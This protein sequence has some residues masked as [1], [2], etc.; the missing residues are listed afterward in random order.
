MCALGAGIVD[1]RAQ[2]AYRCSHRRIIEFAVCPRFGSV[3][4]DVHEVS[5]EG[6]GLICPYE[7]DP[8]TTLLFRPDPCGK[9][10]RAQVVRVTRVG[11]AG[12]HIG[13][14][15]TEPLTAEEL[16]VYLRPPVPLMNRQHGNASFSIV[17]R[18]R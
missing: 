6:I 4:A 10:A 1:R 17:R 12:W 15:F 13:C 11:D 14:A 7:I 16:R 8:G 5:H 9:T 2:S 18:F 3:W